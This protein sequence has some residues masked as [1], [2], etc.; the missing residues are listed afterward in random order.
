MRRYPTGSACLN[1]TLLA[2]TPE[3]SI[4]LCTEGS[5][6]LGSPAHAPTKLTVSKTAG[7]GEA[8]QE[9]FT[10]PLPVNKGPP[11]NFPNSEGFQYEAQAVAEAISGGL[12]ECPEY[13]LEESIVIQA[14][15]DKFRAEVGVVY[16]ADTE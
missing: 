11:L 14:I 4:Y 10:F 16:P 13:P 8:V 9:E 5:L 12:L 15:L 7:R 3:E 6:K 1:F 2:Q